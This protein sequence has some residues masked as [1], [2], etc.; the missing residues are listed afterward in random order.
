MFFQQLGDVAGDDG[1]FEW[2]GLEE[3]KV[4]LPSTFR[5]GASFKIKEAAELGVDIIIPTND[6]MGNINKS[7]Y[8]CWR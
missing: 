5:I 7:Y 6:G 1:L 2:Q 4:K 8:W 3:K